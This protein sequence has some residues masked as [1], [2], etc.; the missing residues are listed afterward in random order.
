[1]N[2]TQGMS[3]VSE[4]YLDTEAP[5]PVDIHVG[6]RIWQRRREMGLSRRALGEIIGVGLK[7]VNKYETAMNRVSAG[8]LHEIGSALGVSVAWFFDGLEG[9]APEG[10]I[11]AESDEAGTGQQEIK[12]LL[13]AYHTIPREV[14]SKF[15]RLVRSIAD[16]EEA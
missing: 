5:D 7:Q 8:R 3:D 4:L 16:E 13:A 11:P 2:Y 12:A 14:R 1:L 9:G 10:D 15:L 6:K